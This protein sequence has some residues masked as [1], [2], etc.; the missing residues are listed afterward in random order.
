MERDTLMFGRPNV[1]AT[2]ARFA[3]IRVKD[4]REQDRNHIVE[5]EFESPLTFD[6]ADEIS[7]ALALD[8]FDDDNGDMVAKREISEVVVSLPIGRQVMTV[9]PHPDLDPLGRLAGVEL[10][11]VR[12]KK[13]EAGTWILS[14]LAMFPFEERTVIGLIRHLKLGVYVTY[15]L[16][17]PALPFDGKAAGAGPDPDDARDVAA[18]SDEPLAPAVKAGPAPKRG[19]GR[20]KGSKGRKNPEQVAVEQIAD[21]RRRLD[22]DRS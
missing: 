20:P 1:Y 15:E 2:L 5:I 16:E 21:A 10:R 7:P 14:W 19:R 3:G 4:E 17:S 9:R 6:L 22:A 12:A 18:G 8:L 13:A 11:R